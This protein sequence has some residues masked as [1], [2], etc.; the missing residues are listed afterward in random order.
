M[1]STKLWRRDSATWSEHPATDT[2]AQCNAILFFFFGRGMMTAN[3]CR[4][5]NPRFW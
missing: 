2:G 4:H 1:T 5:F 3:N